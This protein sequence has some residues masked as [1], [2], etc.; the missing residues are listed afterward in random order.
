MQNHSRE[1]HL[2]FWLV[3]T[4]QWPVWAVLSCPTTVRLSPPSI[5]SCERLRRRSWTRSWRWVGFLPLCLVLSDT[6]E[7]LR[8]CKYMFAWIGSVGDKG[9]RHL[10]RKKKTKKM[11]RAGWGASQNL[12]LFVHVQQRERNI[13]RESEWSE[14]KCRSFFFSFL[15]QQQIGFVTRSLFEVGNH[16][17]MVE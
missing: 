6:L 15:P 1:A 13:E 9:C 7:S 12:Q 10:V 2:L 17:N 11:Q 3:L 14:E 8:D 5:S 4:T 16:F